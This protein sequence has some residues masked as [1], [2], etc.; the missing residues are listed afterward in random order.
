MNPIVKMM[1]RYINMPP[2]K[3][4]A[5]VCI[6][7]VFSAFSDD[8]IRSQKRHSDTKFEDY[9]G[10]KIT[11]YDFIMDPPVLPALFAK[12]DYKI[13]EIT[14]NDGEKEIKITKTFTPQGDVEKIEQKINGQTKTYDLKSKGDPL[15]GFKAAE[16]I[17][18]NL[19]ATPTP[20]VTQ[21]VPEIIEIT[22][23]SDGDHS[24]S[25]GEH[26]HIEGGV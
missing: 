8:C 18:D 2:K 10:Y 26:S 16:R 6:I 21:T 9:K 17:I 3:A 19:T 7:L 11:K 5:V 14:F 13:E 1:K 15:P 23:S 4:L 12:L 20:T 24:I 25:E 22:P